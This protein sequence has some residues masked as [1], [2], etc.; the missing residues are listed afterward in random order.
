MKLFL[1][2]IYLTTL[3]L[4]VIVSSE[5]VAADVTGKWQGTLTIPTGDLEVI[6]VIDAANNTGTMDVPAQSLKGQ[7]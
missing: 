2:L 7:L 4:S 5:V 1:R 6:V 3:I